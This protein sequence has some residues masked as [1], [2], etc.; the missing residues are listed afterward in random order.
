MKFESEYQDLYS[1]ENASAQAFGQI[2]AVILS[3]PQRVH[4]NIEKIGIK[5]KLPPIGYVRV[6]C[7]FLCDSVYQHV[8]GG[9]VSY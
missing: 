6:Y 1:Q 4:F 3:L 7:G 2:V 5:Y 9:I 8:I